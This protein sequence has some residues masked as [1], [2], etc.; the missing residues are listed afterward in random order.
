MSTS[1]FGAFFPKHLLTSSCCLL[2][3]CIVQP[4]RFF[5]VFMLDASAFYRK[6]RF[7]LG[8]GRQGTELQPSQGCEAMK[9]SYRLSL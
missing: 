1:D 5:V 2:P 4:R 6:S 7:F 9:R 8:G 3:W